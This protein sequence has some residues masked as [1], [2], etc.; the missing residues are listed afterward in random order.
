M[1]GMFEKSKNINWLNTTVTVKA[2]VKDE[3]ISQIEAMAE[4]LIK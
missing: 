3:N 4:E 1:K 2:G